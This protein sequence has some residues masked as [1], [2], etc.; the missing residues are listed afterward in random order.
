M[1][2]SKNILDIW[3]KRYFMLKR[4]GKNLEDLYGLSQEVKVFWERI[5]QKFMIKP[6]VKVYIS[7]SHAFSY[8]VALNT[9]CTIVYLFDAHADL[10]Y[11]GLRSLNFE[12]NCANW[13][14]KLLKDGVI[15]EANI[16]YS[17]YTL[18]KP[19]DFEE[20]NDVYDVRYIVWEGIP[21]GIEVA[22]IHICR[23]GAWTPPWYDAKFLEFI[24]DSGLSNLKFIGFTPRKWDTRNISL[25]QQI[26]YMLA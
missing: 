7:E 11:G 10:G 13:L 15:E 21:D 8:D 6:D 1:E 22:A 14:G 26:N 9:G 12:L 24:M 4:L 5:K 3:Y 19:R 17:P 2:N 25:S 23:S 20:I 18:E 16:V